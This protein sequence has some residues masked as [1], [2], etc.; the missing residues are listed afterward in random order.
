MEYL[1]E[2]DI[3]REIGDNPFD[4]LNTGVSFIIESSPS[5]KSNRRALS[6]FVKLAIA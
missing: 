1:I 6:F 4:F 5:L 3:K 2:S